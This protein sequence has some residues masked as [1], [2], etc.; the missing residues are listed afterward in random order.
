MRDMPLCP[1]SPEPTLIPIFANNWAYLRTELNWLDR[2]LMVAVSR[3]RKETQG[4]ERVA[5]TAADRVSSHWWRGMISLDANKAAYDE[6]RPTPSGPPDAARGRYQQ[7]L[8]SRI[9][10]SQQ[11]GVVLAL[12]ALCD[13]LHLSVF[14][15]NLI[16]MALA[17]EV[18]RRYGHLYRFLQSSPNGD[19]SDLPT[20]DLILRLLSRNDADWRL[21]RVHLCTASPLVPLGWVRLLPTG[22]ET[23]LSQRVQLAS[24]LVNFLL[25][26]TPTLGQQERLLSTVEPGSRPLWT[27][28][29]VAVPWEALVLPAAVLQQIQGLSGGLGEPPLDTRMGSLALLAGPSGSGRRMAAAAIAHSAALPWMDIDLATLPIER[30]REIFQSSD[31]YNAAIVLVRGAEV[32]LRRSAP[33]PAEGLQQWLNQRRQISGITLFS[34]VHAESVALQWRRQLTAVVTLPVPSRSDRQILWQRAFPDTVPQAQDLDWL[35]L[36]RQFAI[37]GGE[38]QAIA[39]AAT[40]HWAASGDPVLGWEHLAAA[41]AERGLKLRK[42]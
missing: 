24:S 40:R 3:H 28:R 33:V 20:V 36:A 2:V 4:V 42:A 18:N 14:E 38:I 1:M 11:Q 10:A 16:L 39:Q 37:T 13:R 35:R 25:A 6:H 5:Q 23:V 8:E 26:E 15:K 21:A 27:Q 19:R 31:L 22:A 29:T 30:H 34:V 9:R 12:P 32:W 7:Q 17:P 41:L